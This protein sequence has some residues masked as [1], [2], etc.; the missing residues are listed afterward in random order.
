MDRDRIFA[1]PV[2]PGDEA[3]RF[4]IARFGRAAPGDPRTVAW[5]PFRGRLY[6]V[7]RFGLHRMPRFPEGAN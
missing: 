2:L 3:T 1:F 4:V 7:D 6:Q 5:F